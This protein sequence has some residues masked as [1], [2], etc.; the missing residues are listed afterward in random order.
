MNALSAHVRE[1]AAAHRATFA[2]DPADPRPLHS[3]E[4]LELLAGYADAGAERDI[5]QMRYLLEHHVADGRFAWPEGQSGRAIAHF[6][7]DAPI[8]GE[9]DL[10]QFLMDLCDL[11]KSDAARHIGENER[12]F[13]R[14]DAPALAERFG[15]SAE[16]V[17]HALDAGRGYARLWIVGIP[18]EHELAP[19]ARA[20][21]EA[22]D[23]VIVAPGREQDYGTAPPL[24]VKNVPA[25]EEDDARE[26]IARIAAIDPAALGVAASSR[27]LPRAPSA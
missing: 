17:H 20:E 27:V 11:V 26:Q 5:F 13:D 3:A 10:E 4:A 22:L 23:G 18:A 21:L 24:L 6:G 7:Y 16:R 19:A 25:G 8:S 1:Q 9:W 2:E 12:T 15:L 14:A